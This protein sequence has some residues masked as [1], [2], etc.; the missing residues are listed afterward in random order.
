MYI[1]LGLDV[2]VKDSDIIGF[3][4]LENSTISKHTREFLKRAQEREEVIDVCTD[5]PKSF[6]I[7]NNKNEKKQTVYI[8][9]ISALTIRKRN[10]K[11]HEIGGQY[12]R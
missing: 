1:H 11:N 10:S 2:L 5:I 6:V 8:T 7:V 3:F 4:D 9:Q 12:V